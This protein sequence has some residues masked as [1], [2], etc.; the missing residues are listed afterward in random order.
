MQTPPQPRLRQPDRSIRLPDWCLEQSLPDDHA[1]RD[2][3]AYVSTIDLSAF[4]ATIRAREGRPGRDATDPRLLLA[5][6]LFATVEGI[7]SARWLEEL[8]TEH[9]AFRWL[10]GGVSVNYH[11]LSDFRKDFEAELDALLIDHVAALMHQ[12]VLQ[13]KRVA[14][15]G[16]RT[17][18]HAGTSSFRRAETL[19]TCRQQVAEQLTLLKQQAEEPPG[20]AARRSRAARARHLEEKLQRLQAARVVAAELEVKRAERLRGR[21]KEAAK[22]QGAES[23]KQGGR[24]STTDPEARR[25]KMAD[26]GYRPAYNVQVATT[27]Q[28]GIIV[29]VAVTNAGTDAGLMGPIIEQIESAYGTVPEAMLVDGGFGSIADVEAADAKGIAVYTPLKNAA[30]DQKAGKNPYEPRPQDKVGM[31]KLRRRMGTEAAKKIYRERAATAEWVNAGMRNRGLYQVL[32]RGAQKVRAVVLLQALVHN[33]FA[34]IRICRAKKL[35]GDWIGILRAGLAG[36]RGQT[37]PAMS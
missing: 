12:E 31:A 15:D 37:Q 19:E 17:R 18:A 30:K 11:L 22:Q 34:T 14:Q 35:A 5:L 7:G 25:M 23:D 21:P 26:G 28:E 33:L 27:T 13:L 6:W 9:L 29:G 2:V 4:L 16:M 10:C 32:V 8:C 1:A 24:G 36:R 20:S 3:W